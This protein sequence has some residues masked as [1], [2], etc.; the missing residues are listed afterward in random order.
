MTITRD[1][2]FNPAYYDKFIQQIINKL[3]KSICDRNEDD[4]SSMFNI[5]MEYLMNTDSEFPME[6][7]MYIYSYGYSIRNSQQMAKNIFKDVT[8]VDIKRMDLSSIDIT[9][10]IQISP[11]LS[12]K[13]GPSVW[14]SV[15]EGI[16]TI[17][18]P[19][20]GETLSLDMPVKNI[21]GFK[22]YIPRA[23][24][25]LKAYLED[26]IKKVLTE[27]SIRI[28]PYALITRDP[29][30]GEHFFNLLDILLMPPE[31]H[32]DM[33]LED[34][35]EYF[36]NAMKEEATSYRMSNYANSNVTIYDSMQF[37]V[38]SMITCALGTPNL[39]RF[40]VGN[41]LGGSNLIANFTVTKTE[42][43]SVV[44]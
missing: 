4:A 21:P 30:F 1:D 3:N 33:G 15:K 20:N 14:L 27:S 32:Y 41:R 37:A 38:N 34:E 6:R 23:K 24:V 25:Y 5:N 9:I 13:N 19:Y 28:L 35:L 42:T 43:A 16:I 36:K 8:Y 40:K 44:G 26:H 12:P 39:I 31:Y 11:K 10:P 17:N 29:N 18:L 7:L 22:C 2:L